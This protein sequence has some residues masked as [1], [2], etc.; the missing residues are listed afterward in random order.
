MT[1]PQRPSESR[2]EARRLKITILGLRGCPNVQGGVE[3]HVE[4]LA[5]LL[6]SK[7][8]DVEVVVRAPYV[9][10][11]APRSWRGIAITRLWCWKNK[12]LEAI[13][14]TALGVLRA[15]WTRPDIL[16]IHAIGPA[17]YAP[18]ARALGLKVVVTHHG[19]DYER[20]KWGQLGK[21]AL[22]L[23]EYLGM[24]FANARIIISNAIAQSVKERLGET[25]NIIPNGV[26]L[27]A[28][29]TS[30][31]ALASFGLEPGRYV[32]AVGRIVPEKRHLDLIA[33]FQKANLPGWKLA[34]VGAPDHPDDYSRS[35]DAAATAAANVVMTGFQTGT[36]LAELFGH[37]GLFVL[38]SS[39]EGLPIALLEA[40]AAGVK[41]LASDIA[42]N[43]EIGLDSGSYYPLGDTDALAT[44]LTKWAAAP[45]SSAERQE[46]RAHV[47]AHF[48]WNVVAQRTLA[49]YRRVLAA[50]S[51]AEE[52][53][54]AP[55]STEAGSEAAKAGRA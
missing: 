50:S 15:G 51:A 26:M 55:A 38:P 41:S 22:R 12:S 27:A 6:A 36:P 24:R 53:R 44:L 3:R 14:H 7:G 13:V 17:L 4:Q 42:P 9:P 1:E 21:T 33:A 8:C 54:T 11:S 5:P 18:L 35:V 40:L 20:D 23:G 31:T 47:A 2:A 45:L 25:A 34:I 52:S 19:F 28:P 39:H 30:A 43:R 48:D 16:H 29:R 32:L 37:A 49:V 46:L 10:A